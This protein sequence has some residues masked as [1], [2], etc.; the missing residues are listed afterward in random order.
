[1]GSLKVRIA[2]GGVPVPEHREG[3]VSILTWFHCM[4]MNWRVD[5]WQLGV[6]R[7]DQLYSQLMREPG[8]G[9]D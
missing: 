1:M 3:R 8:L 6:E 7:G 2:V 5:E 9:D 4:G